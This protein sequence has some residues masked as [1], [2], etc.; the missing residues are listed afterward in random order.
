[1][2][3]PGQRRCRHWGIPAESRLDR[4]S[5]GPCV[6]HGWVFTF[7]ILFF[8]IYIYIFSA[9]LPEGLR[10]TRWRVPNVPGSVGDTA[11][12]SLQRLLAPLPPDACDRGDRC[13]FLSRRPIPFHLPRMYKLNQKPVIPPFPA[14]L[15]T[16]AIPGFIPSCS[17]E[18]RR[19]Q[20]EVR[21]IHFKP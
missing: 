10:G 1:M 21:G 12:Q 11:R 2:H 20:F 7:L 15:V 5:P 3:S 19:M 16:L 17:R 4:G 9:G 8:Y 6:G 14:F 13:V 18:M